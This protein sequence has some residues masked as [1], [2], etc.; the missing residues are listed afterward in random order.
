MTIRFTGALLCGGLLF[1]AATTNS[2]AQ[3][4]RN[5]TVQGNYIGTSRGFHQSPADFDADGRRRSSARGVDIGAFEGRAPGTGKGKNRRSGFHVSENES[6]R[7]QDRKANKAGLGTAKPT[8]F[9]RWGRTDGGGAKRTNGSVG[10][11]HET[12]DDGRRTYR[13]SSSLP[14]RHAN[15]HTQS[16]GPSTYFVGTANGGVWRR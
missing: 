14:A 3:A 13:G 5:N 16:G 4:G 8:I 6:P 1:F 10:D 9:D 7:P 15:P 11:P 2:F 12:T